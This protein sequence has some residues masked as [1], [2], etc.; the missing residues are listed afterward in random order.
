MIP[1]YVDNYRVPGIPGAFLFDNFV[2][3]EV[4]EEL[5]RRIEE[6]EWET[7]LKRRVQQF[8]PIYNYQT[9]KLD[10]AKR[11]IP[12]WLRESFGCTPFFTGGA[13]QVIINEYQ[14]GQGITKHTDSKLFGPV[15]ASASLLSDT[16]VVMGKFD[17]SEDKEKYI[18]LKRGSLLVLTEAA[19]YDWYHAIPPVKE[20][21]ISI[22]FRTVPSG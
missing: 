2:K 20:R 22:T 10:E 4:Q 18:E 17:S 21:R 11:P 6:T 15:V 9:K 5:V 8:G 13:N 7:S 3:E 19:R 14:P 12:L 16:Y 1:L